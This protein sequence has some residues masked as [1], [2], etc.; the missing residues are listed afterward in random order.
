MADP[1]HFDMKQSGEHSDMSAPRRPFEAP[2]VE[3][4]GR[5]ET[6]TL[7]TIIIPP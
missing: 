2:A 3:H 7:L 1:A 5:L 6:S 4:L